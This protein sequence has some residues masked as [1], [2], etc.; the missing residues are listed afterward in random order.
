MTAL[1]SAMTAWNVNA[2]QI[3]VAGAGDGAGQH[4]PGPEPGQRVQLRRG[5]GLLGDNAGI[6]RAVTLNGNGGVLDADTQD[7]GNSNLNVSGSISGSGMLLKIGGGSVVL[8]ES[9]ANTYTGGTVIL[10]PSLTVNSTTS[11]GTGNVTVAGGGRLVLTASTNVASTASVLVQGG[12]MTDFNFGIYPGSNSLYGKLELQTDIMPAINPASSGVLL[13]DTNINA[14]GPT[15]TALGAAAPG[16]GYMFLA[17]GSGAANYSGTALAAGAGNT[18]RFGLGYGAINVWS[19][20]LT[21]SANI[22]NV[23]AGLNSWAAQSFTGKITIQGSV[24]IGDF[25]SVGMAAFGVSNGSCLGSTTGSV[26]LDS[27]YLY[28]NV[29]GATTPLVKNNLSYNGTGE[30][31]LYSDPGGAGNTAQIDVSTLTPIGNSFFVVGPTSISYPTFGGENGKTKF[32]V[33]GGM[34]VTNGMVAPSIVFANATNTGDFL[35]YDPTNGFT[36]VSYVALPST[37]GAGTAIASSSG[38]AL[39]GPVSVWALKA[40]GAVTGGQTVTLGGGGLILTGDSVA[41]AVNFQAGTSGTANLTV[42]AN[43]GNAWNTYDSINGTI[44]AGALV[45]GGPGMLNLGAQQ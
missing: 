9:A 4:E 34:T 24:D 21:G 20:C 16:G 41:Q 6:S 1:P 30:V 36:Q 35:A 5:G 15:A 33:T 11:L 40:T 14:G 3:I 29:N 17:S 7:F 23:G 19:S 38:Q 28:Y 45:K 44:T 43:G 2:G 18:Y 25:N 39:T 10:E 27:G 42:Y 12:A 31:G 26:E 8:Q 22:L 37:G 32:V 13:L